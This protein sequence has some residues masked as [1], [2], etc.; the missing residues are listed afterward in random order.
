MLMVLGSLPGRVPTTPAPD[1]EVGGNNDNEQ[2]NCFAF[3]VLEEHPAEQFP[4]ATAETYEAN[5]IARPGGEKKSAL[6]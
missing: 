1:H 2:R 6:V 5:C 4:L 3:F